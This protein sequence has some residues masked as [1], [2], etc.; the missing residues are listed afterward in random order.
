MK[1]YLHA[2]TDNWIDWEAIEEDEDFDIT[3]EDFEDQIFYPY[4]SNAENEVNEKLKIYPEPSVQGGFGG[5]YIFDE[6]GENRWSP[7]DDDDKVI[8]WY[9]WCEKEFNLARKA[10]NAAEYAKLYENWMREVCGI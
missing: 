8:D 9:D 7:Y 1:R 5:V 2:N 10:S 6:S 3:G 4:L